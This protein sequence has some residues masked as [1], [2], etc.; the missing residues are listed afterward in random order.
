M[1]IANSFKGYETLF[2]ALRMFWQMLSKLIIVLLFIHALI[3]STYIYFRHNAIYD[4]VNSYDICL[5]KTYSIAKLTYEINPFKQS[6]KIDYLCENEPLQLDYNF[7]INRFEPYILKKL[8]FIKTKTI[9]II[10]W[11][12]LIYLLL[13]ILLIYFNGKHKKDS[14][15]EYIRGARLINADDLKTSIQKNGNEYLFRI[16]NRINIPLSII[17]RHCIT[18]GKPG[19]GKTQL[20]SRIIDQLIKNGFRAI[21][22]DF[23]GDFISTFYD[24]KKH[25]IFNPL[26]KR[27]MGLRD[28]EMELIEEASDLTISDLNEKTIKKYSKYLSK[29]SNKDKIIPLFEYSFLLDNIRDII[30]GIESNSDQITIKQNA[31][32]T[33]QLIK[34][35]SIF[36]ELRSSIDIDAFCASLIPE[37]ASQDNFWPISSRQLLGSIITYCIHN[38]MT[39]YS[40][41]W[42][43]VNLGNE[44]LLK[45]F[46]TTPGCEEG[47]KLLTEAKTANNIM[48]VMSNYTKPIK[49]LIGTEGDFSIKDWVKNDKD[50][51][52][53]I[54]LS[55]YA[56]IQET[57][58][59][60]LTMFAD[61][62]IKSLLSLDDDHNRRLFFILDEF[63]ELGKIGTIVPLLTGSRSKGGCG[64]ILIQDTARINSIYGKD[65]C[66][67]IV[68]ACGNLIS[69]AV[70]KEEAEFVSECFGTAEI[71]RTEESK[72][73]GVDNI[74]DSISLSK[75]T[76]E[77]R[78]VMPSEVTT[79]PTL[80]FYIHLTDY[81]VSKDKLDIV[82]FPKKSQ[83]YIGRE[84]LLFKKMQSTRSSLSDKSSLFQDINTA[85]EQSKYVEDPDFSEIDPELLLQNIAIKDQSCYGGVDPSGITEPCNEVENSKSEQNE[86]QD[87]VPYPGKPKADNSEKIKDESDGMIF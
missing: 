20:I 56:M 47:T 2:A 81:D 83:S 41:L 13:P 85:D 50:D 17:N 35:W 55:N 61:F 62:S 4:C 9:E 14:Q 25:Y 86:L 26:D 24:F 51:R 60:F 78:I 74:S 44:E 28:I 19:S 59:P 33:S 49:Y 75:Q 21:I 12:S 32:K 52:K 46:K 43:L 66:S 57:I 48:A 36:N 42:M 29:A 3:V 22:H 80:N 39:S 7:F 27:H 30:N 31:E 23:K 58:K 65:G 10:L 69:F 16:T 38:N 76:V 5:I 79:I 64:F 63:G 71:K 68:N 87:S 6:F 11:S 8:N 18:L 73:M 70:K 72:S 34:G 77:K 40:D 54:F 53:I 45:L 84:D 15:D 1:G 82:S 67:T 37:S